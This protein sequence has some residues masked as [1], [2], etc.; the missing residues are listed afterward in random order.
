MLGSRTRRQLVTHLKPLA[1]HTVARLPIVQPQRPFRL[2]SHARDR[3]PLPLLRIR[4]E[5][6][7]GRWQHTRPRKRI[8][9]QRRRRASRRTR[10]CSRPAR[11]RLHAQVPATSVQRQQQQPLNHVR[12]SPPLP[13]R[14]LHNTKHHLRINPRRQPSPVRH[15]QTIADKRRQQHT[16][17]S[18]NRPNRGD[19]PAHTNTP[20]KHPPKQKT[21]ETKPN[22][23]KTSAPPGMGGLSGRTHP[24]ETG[25][26]SRF[27]VS[28]AGSR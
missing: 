27:Q 9:A 15:C 25:Y 28:A 4:L 11:R 24:L 3:T 13:F 5:H 14:P 6:T 18:Y 20:Q 26:L 2:R 12:H 23:E 16:P 17:L 22:R 10:T 1:A 19:N 7:S 21:Q 8:V